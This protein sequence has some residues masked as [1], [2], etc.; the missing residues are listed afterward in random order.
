MRAINP[1][2]VQKP[3]GVVGHRLKPV[4][5]AGGIAQSELPA[6]RDT[7]IP[8]DARAPH[9]AIVVVDHAKAAGGELLAE[10]LRPKE[11]SARPAPSP[12]QRR[13]AIAERL[14][15][16]PQTPDAGESLPGEAVEDASDV[17][18]AGA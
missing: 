9:V 16:E 5:G 2:I 17:L 15:T 11:A 7:G 6:R 14:I 4:C 12:H 10:P 13:S 18:T 3:D 1:Q 8:Q